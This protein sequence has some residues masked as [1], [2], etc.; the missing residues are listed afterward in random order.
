[1]LPHLCYG[2]VVDFAPLHGGTVFF[3]IA[4]SKSGVPDLR[5]VTVKQVRSPFSYRDLTSITVSFK[6]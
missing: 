2:Y 4:F 6:F 3:A 5:T 1:M